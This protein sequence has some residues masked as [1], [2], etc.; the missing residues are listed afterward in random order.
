MHA[1][2][3]VAVALEHADGQK[4]VDVI[5]LGQEH[6]PACGCGG[7]R[8]RGIRRRGRKSRWCRGHTLGRLSEGFLTADEGR[9]GGMTAERKQDIG[10]G[11]GLLAARGIAGLL[12]VVGGCGREDA[13]ARIAVTDL[14]H[15]GRGQII[16]IGDECRGAVEGE[17]VE[18]CRRAFGHVGLAPMKADRGGQCF[19]IHR[20]QYD[21]GVSVCEG[22]RVAEGY[23]RCDRQGH[24]EGEDGAL[25]HVTFQRDGAAHGGNELAG[26][27]ETEPGA[28]AFLGGT[29]AGLLEFLE[30]NALIVF[31]H[32]DAG[33][34]DA[35][36]QCDRGI[37]LIGGRVLAILLS[38]SAEEAQGDAALVGE[39]DGV[40][41][42][43]G[44]D[45]VQAA[46]VSQHLFRQGRV[47]HD[48]QGNAALDGAGG[49]QLG[50]ALGHVFQGEGL[51]FQLEAA[52]FDLGEVQNVVDEPQQRMA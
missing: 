51:V 25:P 35:G 28:A 11:R 22:S 52:G 7:R 37:R 21:K 6:A 36:F 48:G 1:H 49:E 23:V 4:G 34:F 26:D 41:N 10:I 47:H 3:F 39:L 9:D 42:Q 16:R 13:D 29:G 8:R 17:A 43:I 12:A 30:N 24:G 31:A 33:V 2:H 32:T 50:Q 19:G 45:L 40:A 20:L 27:G 15:H 46:L 5:V 38:M 44:K 18:G 14:H